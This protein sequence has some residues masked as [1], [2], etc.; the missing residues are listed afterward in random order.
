MASSGVRRKALGRVLDHLAVAQA[1]RHV[2]VERKRRRQCGVSA[3]SPSGSPP[4]GEAV[5]E[6]DIDPLGIRGMSL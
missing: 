6:H 4:I 3:G 5:R 1:D 2:L